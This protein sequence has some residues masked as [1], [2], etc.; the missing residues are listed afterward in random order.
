ME[1]VKN[2]YEL[3]DIEDPRQEINALK[4]EMEIAKKLYEQHTLEMEKKATE[5]QQELGEKLK[6]ATCLLME[7]RNR[8]KEL[9]TFSQTKLHNWKKE[10]IYQIFTDFQLGALL[11]VTWTSVNVQELRF[12]SQSIRQEVVK[13]Q[14]SYVEEF[15]Q[16]GEKVGALGHAAANYSAI[17]VEN[18][19]LHNE[20]QELKGVII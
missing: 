7:S 1:I 12:S 20:V 15:N 8:I 10:H 11:C 9:E 6:E 13:T 17:L 3:K 18:H 5:A 4:K 19:K 2:S 16:L 14:K